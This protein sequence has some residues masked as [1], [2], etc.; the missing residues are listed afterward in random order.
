[1]CAYEF[2]LN[3]L[4][5]LHLLRGRVR[6]VLSVVGVEFVMVSCA[7]LPYTV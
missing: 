6:T 4:G 1:M 5:F 7:G 2:P 3:A